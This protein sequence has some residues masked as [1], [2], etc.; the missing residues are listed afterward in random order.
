M[1]GV[2]DDALSILVVEYPVAGLQQ[3]FG[4]RFQAL[5]SGDSQVE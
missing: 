3:G 5:V 2:K 4:F 1:N